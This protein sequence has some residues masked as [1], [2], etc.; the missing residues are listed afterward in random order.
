MGKYDEWIKTAPERQRFNM[1]RSAADDVLGKFTGDKSAHVRWGIATNELASDETLRA[2]LWNEADKDVIRAVCEHKNASAYTLVVALRHSAFAAWRALES[3]NAGESVWFEAL[4]SEFPNVSM[5]AQ[6]LLSEATQDPGL[7]RAMCKAKTGGLVS[8][9][10]L[11]VLQA[12]RSV[13]VR[14]YTFTKRVW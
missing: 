3:P 6:K 8:K 2:L 10:V 7:V 9:V 5:A 4:D 1:V 14:W 11:Q 13:L 12:R